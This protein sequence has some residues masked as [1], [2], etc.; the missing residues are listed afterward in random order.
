MCVPLRLAA[1]WNVLCDSRE[2]L[3]QESRAMPFRWSRPVLSLVA[4]VAVACSS[5]ATP[6][7][8]PDGGQP[9]AQC[10]GVPAK[11][12]NEVYDTY[13]SEKN[14]TGCSA[15][16]CHGTGAGLLTFTDAQ[17]MWMATVGKA[18]AADPSKLLV[19]PNDPA[20]SF[21]FEKLGPSAV[22]R[23]PS[24][25]P[26][27][28]E[29]A[30]NAVRGW[31]CAGAPAPAVEQTDGGSPDGGDGAD[32]GTP[33]FGITQFAPSSGV[34]GTSVTITG[35]GFGAE[36][37]KVGVSFNGTTAVVTSVSDDTI[38]TQ[39]PAGAT[40]GKIA[41]TVNGEGVLSADSFAVIQPNPAPTLSS[42]SPTSITV[43][44]PDVELT[45]TGDQFVA[46][47]TVELDGTMVTTQFVSATELKATLAA[48][49]FQSAGSHTITV[50]N[51]GPGGG[52]STGASFVVQNPVPRVDGLAPETIAVGSPAT[53]VVVKGNGFV[54]QS[55]V[56]VSGTEVT[57]SNI[58]NSELTISVPAAM[59]ASTGTLSVVV[60]NPTPGGG[61]SAAKTI[62]VENPVPEITQL[63]P[64][65]LQAG[66]ASTTLSIAGTG[67][68]GSTAVLWDGAALPTTVQ[69]ATSVT[70]SLDAS[71]YA[72]GGTYSVS[73][74][75]PTPGGGEGTSLQF[76][77]M[78]PPP[79]V[80]SINPALVSTNT[81][82]FALTVNGTG[83]N[84]ASVVNLDGAPVTT[85]L[86]NGTTLTGQMPTFVTAGT[87]TIS[88]TN[89][90]PGGGL[91]SPVT[92]TV[93]AESVP[94]ITSLSPS[95]G[96]ANTSFSLTINGSGF[97]CSA[98]ASIVT[99]GNNVISPS[100]C[101]STQLVVTVPAS[102]AGTYAVQVQNQAVVS[103]SASLSIVTPNP[104]P[105]LTSLS[106][107]SGLAG[108]AAFTLTVNGS[109]FIASSQVT[110]N[111]MARSTTFVSSTQLTAALSA[112][113][114]ASAGSYAVV[115]TNPS[116]GGG[117][118]NSLSFSVVTP[119]P[120][121]TITS[122]V[123]SSAN[124]N[125]GAQSVEVNG[126]GFLASS[127]VT[128]GGQSRTLN[129][130][131]SSKV[132]IDLL[133]TDLQ[134]P[135]SFPLVI[136]NPAPGGGAS[137]SFNF[138]VVALNPVPVISGLSP[139]SATAGG[140]ALTLTV[141]GSGFVQGSSI[142]FNSVTKTTT[143][144][145]SAQLTATLSTSDVASAG[146]FVV[147]VSSPAP[148]G[149]SSNASAFT[150]NNAAPAL[151][152]ILPNTVTVGASGQSL[153]VTGS[154]FVS[155]SVVRIDGADR[156]THFV[157]STQIT[158]DL[159][160]SDFTAT[161]TRMITVFNPS[162][163]GGATSGLTLTVASQP[164]PVPTIST[165]SPCGT[166]VN[167]TGFTL[168]IN[169][170]NFL[171]TS[172]LTINGISMTPTYVSST[173][174][175]ASVAS[176]FFT[177]APTGNTANVV[178]TN[179]TPGGGSATT[180]MGVGS[181]KSTLSQNVQGIFTLN[182]ATSGC[183]GGMV[184]AQTP[185]LKSGLS[186]AALVGKTC[187]EC[188]PRLFV[189]SCDPSSTGSYLIAKITNSSDICS[190]TQMPKT[191]LLGVSDRQT[192]IDWVAQ[193]APP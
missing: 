146:S 125:S 39:V 138:T 122:L 120:K 130:V 155:S 102:S 76:T 114:V 156:T 110:F 165:L 29:A 14:A 105:V 65:T 64:I 157:N 22:G 101:S 127:T 31:I 25:G 68:V 161:G 30:L 150:V 181:A 131:S 183:H 66:G 176:S 89:P 52:T 86:V 38:T 53:S 168:T 124:Q 56:M 87:H 42:I 96:L 135:G 90:A 49:I 92:L 59:L 154:N 28:D 103:N 21:L 15:S 8:E 184:V 175:T 18:S 11:S 74:R 91:S 100:S 16:G 10:D 186:Y 43:G 69:S 145:S 189:K 93:T 123:P 55:Q 171:P 58:A 45:V 179:P 182:C 80:S 6:N 148:G 40:S 117:T 134:T 32:A 2:V 36:V 163:G 160:A 62:N 107:S 20:H 70:A 178:V 129:F 118:S 41:V 159:L 139:S 177:A 187:T 23:M 142:V 164:N 128:F 61:T 85:T 95:T 82:A 50:T 112:S 115:V 3:M 9:P 119:N 167:A 83:F 136:T 153:T 147:T 75:N 60:T 94:V 35:F 140:A 185:N 190:G 47:S 173:Q 48:S 51:P 152:S 191:G 71:L 149:G 158:A 12:F 78:N 174:L 143:F 72:V 170:T 5:P 63:Q 46:L 7:V 106:P 132:T 144:V 17:S 88:V 188:P 13:F 4:L 172:T 79:S 67:I 109:G 37:S 192:I 121:P 113:D 77:V 166:Y 73:L 137:N 54:A 116:P 151:T 34:V 19:S 99:V 27:L 57:A 104:V 108:D 84:A 133:A 24:G 141:N 98:P 111:G 126:S 180:T 169:G 26:Y 1:A 193:G 33:A 97:R 162:P 44:T 81:A